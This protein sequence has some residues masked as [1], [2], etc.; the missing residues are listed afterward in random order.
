MK[1]LKFGETNTGL[2][3]GGI[4]VA[5]GALVMLFGF[6]RILILVCLFGV[7]Y[8]IGTVDNKED[9]FKQQV[10]KVIPD[11][12]AQP[13]NL[14]EEIAREQE[15]IKDIADF[16]AVHLFYNGIISSGI[17]P[18]LFD[19]TLKEKTQ[20]VRRDLAAQRVNYVKIGS[21]M[22]LDQPEMTSVAVE[23]AVIF[24]I[25]SYLA[26]SGP[27]SAALFDLCVAFDLKVGFD[28]PGFQPDPL[29]GGG[30]SVI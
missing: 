7:G 30:S 1:K 26:Q 17:E 12:S 3:L 24:G 4:L 29:Q 22:D 20:P 15:Q 14:K 23:I 8:F 18:H 27:F 19:R 2:I 21:V 9:F 10:R 28:Q 16:K 5:L 11:K 13:I 25:D 6:W